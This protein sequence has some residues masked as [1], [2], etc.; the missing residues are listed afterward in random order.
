MDA[1]LVDVSLDVSSS[2]RLMWGLERGE[3]DFTLSRV[4]AHDYSRDFDI[5]PARR[6]AVLLMVRRGHPMAAAG[7]VSTT[8][9]ST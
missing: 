6:E 8:M 1:P 4:G 3:Y 5:R 7:P 9:S 2:S